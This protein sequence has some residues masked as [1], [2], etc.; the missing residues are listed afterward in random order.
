MSDQ[1][2]PLTRFQLAVN[3]FIAGAFILLGVGA[4]WRLIAEFAAMRA[5]FGDWL[6]LIFPALC[7]AAGI[8]IFIGLRRGPRVAPLHGNR[9]GPRL[10]FRSAA[11]GALVVNIWLVQLLH[12]PT[13]KDAIIALIAMGLVLFVL[14]VFWRAV[15]EDRQLGAGKSGPGPGSAD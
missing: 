3:Y 2:V 7:L 10:F 12:Q 13:L 9:K 15:D 8:A 4:G 6:I 5:D 11:G 1:T 14:W